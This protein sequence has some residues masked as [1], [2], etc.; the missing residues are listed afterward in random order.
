MC[1]VNI[2][3][4]YYMGDLTAAWDFITSTTEINE[5]EIVNFVVEQ[6]SS[7][8]TWHLAAYYLFMLVFQVVFISGFG[9]VSCSVVQHLHVFLVSPLFPPLTFKGT[10]SSSPSPKRCLLWESL[11]TTNC[12]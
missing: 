10:F 12:I 1:I 6:I 8:T 7:Y 3:M 11:L 5:D 9:Y 4:G 2:A